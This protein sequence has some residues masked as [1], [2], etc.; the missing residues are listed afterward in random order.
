VLE[1]RADGVPDITPVPDAIDKPAGKPVADHD[2]GP[3]PPL[4]ATVAE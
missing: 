4:A 2:S 1:P 3:T